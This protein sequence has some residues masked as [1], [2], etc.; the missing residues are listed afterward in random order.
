MILSLLVPVL[1]FIFKSHLSPVWLG[2]GF[3]L[4]IR[5]KGFC[6]LPLNAPDRLSYG[7]YSTCFLPVDTSPSCLK[8][9]LCLLK[10]KAS[11]SSSTSTE[12]I[13]LPL[14]SVDLC[15][16]WLGLLSLSSHCNTQTKKKFWTSPVFHIYF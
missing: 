2:L 8:L 11:T 16:N 9:D 7:L 12:S 4:I 1:G 14:F 10:L 13:N 5:C 3:S 6:L 15:R